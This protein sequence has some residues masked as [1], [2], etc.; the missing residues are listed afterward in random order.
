MQRASHERPTMRGMRSAPLLILMLLA[1]LGWG[2]RRIA[3]DGKTEWRKTP[4]QPRVRSSRRVMP[5][6]S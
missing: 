1:L 3:L 2:L 6:S 4:R 5:A